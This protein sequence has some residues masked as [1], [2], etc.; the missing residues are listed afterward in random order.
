MGAEV[1]F[2]GADQ[3]ELQIWRRDSEGGNVY[4]KTNYSLIVPNATSDPSVHEYYPDTPLEFQEGDILGVYTPNNSNSQLVVYYQQD[5]G[6]ENYRNTNVDPPTP[7]TFTLQRAGNQYDYPLVAVEI[8]T[9]IMPIQIVI[10]LSMIAGI[11][12]IID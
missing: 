2:G 10:H 3:P 4:T 9:G 8:S 7:S 12:V 6:P 11:I 5:T 1:R